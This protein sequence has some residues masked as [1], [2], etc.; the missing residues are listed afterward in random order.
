M[1]EFSSTTS[2][3]NNGPIYIAHGLTSSKIISVEALVEYYTGGFVSVGYTPSANLNFNYLI[4]PTDIVIVNNAVDCTG[5]HIC[6]K[7]V[8][9]VVTYKE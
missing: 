9:V 8:K 2:G 6:G 1:K 5:D 3:T 7:P 4:T